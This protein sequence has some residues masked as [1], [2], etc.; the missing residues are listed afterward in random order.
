MDFTR[1]GFIRVGAVAP[2][3]ELANPMTNARNI[4]EAYEKASRQSISL[5]LTPELSL[6]GYTCEDLFTGSDLRANVERALRWL[7]P[8]VQDVCL[9]VGAPL[10]S[11]NG[12][13]LNCALVLADSRIIGAVPK[14][15]IPNHEEFYEK[16]W[17]Q[18]GSNAHEIVDFADHRFQLS[19]NQL[20][21]VG[22]AR[23]AIEICEDLWLPNPPSTTH[24]LHGADIVLNLSASNEIVGKAD[25]R[26]QL[27][28]MQSAKL[29]CGYVYAGS[30]PSESSKDLVFGGHLLAA[31][32]GVLVGESERFSLAGSDLCVEIDVEKLRYS[33]LRNSAFSQVTSDTNY[34][35]HR[36]ADAQPI[37]KLKRTFSEQPFV[38]EDKE[39]ADDRAAEILAIQ[40]TGLTRRLK[41]SS[42]KNLVIGLSGGLDSTLAF[43]VCIEAIANLNRSPDTIIAVTMPGPG[44]SD[45]TLESVQQLTTET[46]TP[47]RVIDINDAVT[48]HLRAIGHDGAQDTTF[49]NVQARE[50][51]QLLFDIANQDDALVV[52]TGDLSELAL[53]WCTFNADHMSSYNVNVAVPK[54]LVAHL[55]KWYA[56]NRACERLRAV[57][58]R[59]LDTP[60]SPEL[61]PS[62]EG[63]ISQLTETLIGPYELHDFFLFHLMR[64][65]ASSRKLFDLGCEVF[66][67][68]YSV[69]AIRT[70]LKIFY[71]RFYANQFKRSTLPAGPKIGTVNLS[72][73]GD[74]RMPDEADPSE[75]LKAIDSY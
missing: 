36:L 11:R 65:G 62:D 9:V 29:N 16:R 47:V 56:I 42:C 25:Y 68:T 66:S 50:R 38:P 67:R 15:A 60:I 4:F 22:D 37:E 17:F 35:L 19:K 6:T 73:R 21:E 3:I 1:H 53:G 14:S 69:D 59:I 57:L 18:S 2:V 32:N 40:T 30:G 10:P 45:H 58:T 52:G 20:F 33:R 49:E 7:V 31:E 70:T 5:V 41:A 8:R 75:I 48:N 72:P 43:L 54:T 39:E 26:R 74:W 27:V 63:E 71:S 12:L 23:F 51:T 46:S 64:S 61:L 55:V 34:E 13:L 44:T 24:G 28:R